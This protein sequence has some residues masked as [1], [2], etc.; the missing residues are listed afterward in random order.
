MNP[1]WQLV[2]SFDEVKGEYNVSLQHTPDYLAWSG[3]KGDIAPDLVTNDYV[4][5]TLSFNERSKGWVSF[6]SFIPETGLSINGEY[7]TGAKGTS[8]IGVWSHHDE[9]VAANNFYG[10]QYN[11]TIDILFNDNP[12]VIKG[13]ATINYEGSQARVVQDTGDNQYYNLN[14][15]SG[16]Y[17]S[18]IET[19]QQQGNV[20][21]FIN[22]E[23]KW[24][25]NVFGEETTI[26]NYSTTL[27]T[28]EFS[29]QGLGTPSDTSFTTPPNVTIT[30]IEDG[31]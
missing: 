16:W 22:K 31:E 8:G 21:E 2:G 24:F 4:N 6:K 1:T 5:T 9:T 10:T 19:D 27:D 15:I 20:Q 25:N 13:F 28:S 12:S 3:R 11:S 14:N 18:S 17:V 29:V 7:L 23:G 26:D 30:I